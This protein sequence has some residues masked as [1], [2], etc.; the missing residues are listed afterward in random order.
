MLIFHCDPISGFYGLHIDGIH[1]IKA[2]HLMIDHM[3]ADF[4][5]KHNKSVFS[6]E[7]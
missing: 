5:N 4:I 2:C 6:F 1:A 3:F 7:I